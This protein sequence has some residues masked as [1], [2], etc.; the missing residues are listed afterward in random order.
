MALIKCTDCGLY[1][2][3]FAASCVSC[4]RPIAASASLDQGSPLG[5]GEP[6]PIAAPEAW[7][8]LSNGRQYGPMQV[9][10]MRTFFT[11]GMVRAS[12]VV[13]SPGSA[14]PITAAQAASLLQV[15]P[16]PGQPAAAAPPVRAMVRQPVVQEVV[17]APT[18]NVASDSAPADGG[19][20]PATAAPPPDTVA[21]AQPPTDAKDAGAAVPVPARPPIA[22]V[23][24]MTEVEPGLGWR[25]I[26]LWMAVLFAAQL[27]ALPRHNQ[28][29]QP[30]FWEFIGTSLARYS[31]LAALCVV[32]VLAVGGMILGRLPG[33]KGPLWAM[34]L[35]YAV[36]LG[37]KAFHP[38]PPLAA[39][40]IS[41]GSV[42]PASP[43][44]TQPMVQNATTTTRPGNSADVDA[45]QSRSSSTHEPMAT[46]P[47]SFGPPTP[48]RGYTDW[49]GFVDVLKRQG[50]WQ[51]LVELALQWTAA[52]P[53]SLDAWTYLGLAQG[54]VGQHR[55]AEEAFLRALRIAP[56]DH[57]VLY[58]L[59]STYNHM[60]R[61]QLAIDSYRRALARR[62]NHAHSW[63]NMGNCLARLGRTEE[64]LAAW[65][66]ATQINP[67]D[68]MFWNNMGEQYYR[69][70]R[71]AL[72]IEAYRKVL[73]LEPG[74]H[75]G[76]TGLQN[77]QVMQRLKGDG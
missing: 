8:L 56:G 27:Y 46:Q 16:P 32:V 21:A 33:A 42:Q 6:G 43:T 36:L 48:F 49:H 38:E 14:T 75:K 59:G 67:T 60:G 44:S 19:A 47:V 11:S 39:T 65:T 26:G 77:A 31:G 64:A 3:E 53:G 29:V 62:P 2:S 41:A 68:V 25:G 4:G 70:A 61:C 63:N 17:A 50:K 66:R 57:I 45:G 28:A 71:Y 51:S 69:L 22:P 55:L 24:V 76:L 74:N 5:H 30:T 7:W 72:A 23:L 9:H 73:A 20:S 18:A 37:N 10:E 58:N 40:V 52:E 35:A 12:D 15:M 34:T 13:R 54:E 1:V